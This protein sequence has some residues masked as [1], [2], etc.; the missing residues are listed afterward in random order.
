MER[1]AFN[2]GLAGAGLA[3]PF[4][5]TVARSATPD[6]RIAQAMETI[7]LAIL[8]KNPQF[9]ITTITNQLDRCQRYVNGQIIEGDPHSHAVLI[10]GADQ[11]HGWQR[12]KWFRNYQ[13][14]A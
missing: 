3:L 6:E 5:G 13:A 4:L 14:S 9:E 11:T 10:F 1:R 12:A 2:K 8:E 7:R